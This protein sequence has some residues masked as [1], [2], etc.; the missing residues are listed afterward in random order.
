[1]QIMWVIGNYLIRWIYE[2]I[3]YHRKLQDNKLLKFSWVI[4][5]SLRNK[6]INESKGSH[7]S[8]NSNR[9]VLQK[10]NSGSESSASS[11]RAK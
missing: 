9:D 3:F 2:H 11:T 6:N 8:F 7:S 5:H 4:K 10:R 1:M